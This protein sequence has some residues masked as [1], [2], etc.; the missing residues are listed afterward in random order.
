MR[1]RPPVSDYRTM[2]I[3]LY[4]FLLSDNRI[5]DRRILETIGLFD[6]RSRSQSIRLSDIGH[7]KYK[8]SV[9]HIIIYAHI[10]QT[11]CV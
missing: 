1:P 6:I 2:A 11:S 8:L 3:G 4:F 9:A 5:S 10:E 7:I